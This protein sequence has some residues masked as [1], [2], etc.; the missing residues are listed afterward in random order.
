[1]E[2]MARFFNRLAE[3]FS[4]I[5][6]VVAFTMERFERNRFHQRAKELYRKAMRL[7]WYSSLARMNNELLGVG[8]ICLAILAGGYLVLS[9]E[10]HLFGVK[11][12]DRPLSFGAIMVF[13]AFLAGVSDPAR[14]LADVYSSLQAA[15]AAADRVYPLL[16]RKSAISDPPTP[17]PF[18]SRDVS[19]AFEAVHFHYVP[20][21]PVLRDVN[22][23][24]R[25]GETVAFVGP[26]GCGKTTLANL[27][28]RFYDPVAGAVRLGGVDLRELKLRE[29]RRRIGVVTQ[30][31]VLFDDTI[32]DNIRYGSLHASDEQVIEA[33]K[34]A[35]IHRFIE[36]LDEGYDTHVGERGGR[37]SGGQRQ[38][39]ALARAILRDPAIL[40]L[41]E[42]TSQ[43]DP[44][45]EQMIQLA[46]ES[47]TR[48]RTT[49]MITH[50]M[51]TLS[52]ADRI[53]VINAGAIADVGAHDELIAR[54]PLYRRLQRTEFK[55]SA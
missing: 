15:A 14:K 32:R 8:V 29:I 3:S 5:H 43:I 20:G 49:I 37:L 41:D 2:E 16:D 26:N 13:Y 27:A 42:A 12:T 9:Q 40:L 11:M 34:K 46:L 35:H 39:I 33:A 25:D 54:C 47:F 10:T 44:E 45:S 24:I 21:K 48:G 23:H 31:T 36:S 55:L 19:L 18:P 38:R 50:R 1:M 52:L 22:L 28:P 17:R 51:A 4:G 53:V 30:Q 7:V 6:V